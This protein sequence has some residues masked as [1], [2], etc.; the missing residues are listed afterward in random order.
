MSDTRSGPE[1]RRVMR[2]DLLRPCREGN[3]EPHLVHL[4]DLSALGLRLAHREPWPAGVV[5]SVEL[6]PILGAVRLPGRVVWTQHRGT[7]RVLE[8]DQRCP[9]E[10]GVEFA[11][12]T[13]EQQAALAMA[14]ATFRT[15]QGG[16]GHG[17]MPT[18]TPP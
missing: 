2:L 12:L 7:D 11:V 6:P 17:A 1:R 14:L 13:A 10:S 8:D 18:D 16:L 15:A 4:L 5:C 9:Y 3:R